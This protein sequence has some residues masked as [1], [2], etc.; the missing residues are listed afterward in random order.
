MV[1][2]AALGPIGIILALEVS[3]LARSNG[4]WYQLL[5]VCAWE[6]GRYTP[7]SSYVSF[8]NRYFRRIMRMSPREYRR[9]ARA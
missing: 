7:S 8:F 5:D 4:D 1:A 2:M 6:P 3:R 9:R